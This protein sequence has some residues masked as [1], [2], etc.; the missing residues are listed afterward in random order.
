MLTYNSLSLYLQI[1]INI[2]L[3]TGLILFV[4]TGIKLKTVLFLFLS[5]ESVLEM[6]D[7]IGRLMKLNTFNTYNYSLSQ[8]FGLIMLTEI[9]NVYFIRIPRLVK[10][11][12]YVYAT[13]CLI[14]NLVYVQNIKSVTFYSN[15][16]STVIICSFAAV[17]FLNVIRKSRVDRDLLIVNITVF[18]FFSIESLISTTFNFLISNHLT[19]VAPIWLFRGVLLW[20]FYIAF[21]NL[22]CRIG[23]IRA[24]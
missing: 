9:Y 23:K 13:M 22:G 18:L 11:V 6:S 4:K 15:I 24:W 3:L 19:W 12:V 1:I 16:I 8:F 14:L 21:I 7:L 10:L 17:Y 2:T 5:G 20:S